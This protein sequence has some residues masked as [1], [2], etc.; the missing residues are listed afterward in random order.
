L[1]IGPRI[2]DSHIAQAEEEQ[3]ALFIAHASIELPPAAPAAAALLH[4]DEP[5]AHA[6][7]GDSS[8]NDKTDG[9][10]LDIGAT[11]HMTGRREFSE[12]DSGVRG[13]VK[14]GDASAVQIK[15]V[16]SVVF[17]AKTG[18]HRLLTGVYNIPALRNSII[19]LGQ[20]DESGSRVEIEHGVLRIWD[21]RRRLLVKVNRSNRLYVLHA[22]VAQPLCLAAR[23]DDDAWRWHER[24]GHLN[25]EALR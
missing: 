17:V 8:G 14:F 12:L 15:G 13:T 22:Q 9:W 19:S 4:L 20:L 18:E 5:K 21:H 10:C 23:R 25:F 2:V 16:G 3:P 24:F 1:V 7:L 11:H 6:L